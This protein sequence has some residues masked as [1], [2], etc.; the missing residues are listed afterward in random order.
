MRPYGDRHL[1]TAYWSISVIALTNIILPQKLFA[2][3]VFYSACGKKTT[4][5]WINQQMATLLQTDWQHITLTIPDK[6]WL[7]FQENRSLRRI[8][9]SVYTTYP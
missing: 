9:S 8:Y 6:P 7:L 2:L 1:Y 3:D 5:L 4:D